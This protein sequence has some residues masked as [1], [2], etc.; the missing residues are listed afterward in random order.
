M[1]SSILSNHID[2]STE[3]QSPPVDDHSDP[4]QSPAPVAPPPTAPDSGPRETTQA[5]WQRGPVASSASRDAP[6]RGREAVD[7]QSNGS[8]DWKTDH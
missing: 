8:D 1:P 3:D 4:A 5:Q 7:N 6:G 2:E